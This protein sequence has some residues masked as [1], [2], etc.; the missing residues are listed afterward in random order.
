VEERLL[1]QL[2]EEI[3]VRYADRVLVNDG[4]PAGLAQ[5]ARELAD[6]LRAAW[7][8]RERATH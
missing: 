5:A 3:R 1:R 2:P 6:S 4:S 8:S 7:Q